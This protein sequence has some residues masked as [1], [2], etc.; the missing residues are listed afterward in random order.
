MSLAVELYK[1]SN[2]LEPLCTVILITL[3]ILSPCQKRKMMPVS[4]SSV[5]VTGRQRFALP[6]NS[7]TLGIPNCLVT[8]ARK[9]NH[10][11]E[12]SIL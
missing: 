6:S 7:G 2:N 9:P 5:N 4:C 1:Y 12:H 11:Q 3:P 8:G 10:K